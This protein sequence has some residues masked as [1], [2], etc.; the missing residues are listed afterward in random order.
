MLHISHLDSQMHQVQRRLP[1]ELLAWRTRIWPSWR[2]HSQGT[3]QLL[4]DRQEDA[5]LQQKQIFLSPV[6]S[7]SNYLPPTTLNQELVKVLLYFN[8]LQCT[9]RIRHTVPSKN[10]KKYSPWSKTKSHSWLHYHAAMHSVKWQ[11]QPSSQHLGSGEFNTLCS[12]NQ[13]IDIS[14]RYYFSC[15]PCFVNWRKRCC[16]ALKVAAWAWLCD[17]MRQPGQL[18]GSCF[19]ECCHGNRASR[20]AAVFC[21]NSGK[22]AA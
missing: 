3:P 21:T 15:K 17:A 8:S 10:E 7:L 9:R 12:D 20:A 13:N 19:A 18:A 14:N 1:G 4:E 22:A 16:L 2:S 11:T 5:H 6:I